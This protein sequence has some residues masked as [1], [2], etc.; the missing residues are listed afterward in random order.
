MSDEDDK[1]PSHD[2]SPELHK[3]LFF[4]M[5]RLSAEGVKLAE[6]DFSG[7]C[8]EGSINDISLDGKYIDDDELS[9]FAY[10]LLDETGIDWYNDAG[11]HGDMTFDVEKHTFTFDV[12]QYEEI[13]HQIVDTTVQFGEWTDEEQPSVPEASTATS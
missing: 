6:I 3:R 10:D 2:L 9:Q 4:L 1:I 12:S 8:D 5:V 7:S 13:S 11:G